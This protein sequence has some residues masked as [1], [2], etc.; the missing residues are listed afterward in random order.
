MSPLPKMPNS[1]DIAWLPSNKVI[2]ENEFRKTQTCRDLQHGFENKNADLLTDICAYFTAANPDSLLRI[3]SLGW[4][5][6]GQ[7][8][9][10]WAG[11]VENWRFK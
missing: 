2:D 1:S 6:F 3:D 7:G 4:E 10:R 5:L 11:S 8:V 9:L